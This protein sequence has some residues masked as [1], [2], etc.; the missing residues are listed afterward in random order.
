M[1]TKTKIWLGVGAFMLVGTVRQV[2]FL[3]SLPKPRPAQMGCRPYRPTSAPA[4]TAARG[5][6]IAEHAGHGQDGGEGGES[7][8]LA[9][10]PPE[11]AFAVRIALLRGHLLV[12]DELVKQQQWNAA[13]PHFLHPTEEI[14]GDIK[15]QLER[16]QGRRRS[17]V[18]SRRS[19]TSSRPRRAAPITPR[20]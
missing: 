19:P 18:R 10:L 3:R 6:V 8:G 12:G 14:Y 15:E 13:L 20:R 5:V 17:M 16:I 9:N 2:R 7:Q 1:K 11:L 4:P